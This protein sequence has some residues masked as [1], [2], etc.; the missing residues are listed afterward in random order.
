[1]NKGGMEGGRERVAVKQGCDYVDGR[2]DR[3]G[4]ARGQFGDV[5]GPPGSQQEQPS[6]T[7]PPSVD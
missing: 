1:M 2:C 7:N 6:S 3:L 4:G 5:V